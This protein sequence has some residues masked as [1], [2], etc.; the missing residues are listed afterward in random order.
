MCLR[1]QILHRQVST[2]PQY[3]PSASYLQVQA[4]IDEMSR[5]QHGTY[6]S[7]VAAPVGEKGYHCI[8]LGHSL[9]SAVQSPQ[10][11]A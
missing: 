10:L 2:G 4:G 9:P 5:W 3:P 6:I 7:E 8:G 11:Q 1:A